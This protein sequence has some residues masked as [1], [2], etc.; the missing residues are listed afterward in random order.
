MRCA[1]PWE[2]EDRTASGQ[3]YALTFDDGPHAQG[4][5]AVLELLAAAGVRATFF[6]VGEQILRNPALA[7][8]IARPATGWACT[9]TDTA[10]CC[11]SR[12]G[13]SARTSCERRR[14]SR[15]PPGARRRSTGRPTESSTPQPSR[16]ARRRGWRTLLWSHWG[17]DWEARA[18]AESIAA[19]VTAGAGDGAG[20]AA[21]R[22]RRL[23]S[24]RLLAA[25]GRGAAAGAGDTRRARA[26]AGG[27]LRS[28]DGLGRPAG[29]SHWGVDAAARSGVAPRSDAVRP[30]GADGRRQHR[31]AAHALVGRGARDRVAV[32]GLRRDQQPRAAAPARR[33]RARLG[34][35]APGALAR[36][37]TPKSRSTAGWRAT[38]RSACCS[39]TT[40][41]TPT[42]S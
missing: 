2:I 5:P 10:T 26:P 24:P 33:A 32:L 40:T 41:T 30:T 36:T 29:D 42:S 7:G 37:S 20:A 16:L 18:T 11:G 8:E 38:T 9:A 6:L 35:A 17:R 25:H 28:R 14:S 39:P 21:A 31:T 27:A 19:L 1:D 22:C 23:L 4:T 34:R 3:G 12:R 15:R 13:K